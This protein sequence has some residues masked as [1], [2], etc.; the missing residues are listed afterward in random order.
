MQKNY[1]CFHRSSSQYFSLLADVELEVVFLFTD[2]FC[3]IQPHL[4]QVMERICGSNEPF[5]S[6]S[7][8][9]W[10]RGGDGTL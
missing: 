2:T 6:K 8:W 1:A 10:V 4:S 7:Q 3:I 5:S 9:A